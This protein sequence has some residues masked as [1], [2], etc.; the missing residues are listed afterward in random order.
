MNPRFFLYPVLLNGLL[1]SWPGLLLAQPAAPSPPVATEISTPPPTRWFQ[2]L[3]LREGLA[4]NF[5]TAI[6]QDRSGF[7]WIGTVKGLTRF[8]GRNCRNFTR[9]AGNPQSLSHRVVR[10]VLTARNGTLWVGTQ[11]GLD[12]YDPAVQ[13]FRRHSFERFGANGNIVSKLAET[14]DGILWCGTKDGLVRFDPV[15]GQAR[16]L[17][18]PADAA[19]RADANTI[20]S[21]LIN[22]PTI[23]VGTQAG[24]YA[25]NWRTN[26][27]RTFRHQES[28]PS[29]LPGDYVAALAKNPHTNELVVGTNNGFVALLDQATGAFRRLPLLAGNQAVASLLYTTT[30]ALWVGLGSGGLHQYNPVTNTFTAYLSEEL[31]PRSLGCNCVK[32]LFEDRNGLVWIVTDDVGIN[33]TNPTIEKF[34][35][36]FDEV[37]YRPASSLGLAALKLSVGKKNELWVAT[38]EGLLQID[39]KTRTFSQH[40]HNPKDPNSLGTDFLYTVLAD[41]RGV[42]WAGG[43][44]LTRFDLINNRFLRIPC[45]VSPDKTRGAQRDFVAGDQVFS[46]IESRDGRIFIGTSDKLT[47]YDPRTNTFSNRFT[48]EYIRKLPGKNY[49]ILYL[50]RHD[51]L[52]VGGFGPVYKISPDWQLLTQYTHDENNPNTLPDEGVTG[53][54]EDAAGYI[55]MATDNGLARLDERSGRFRTF[56]TQHGLPSN[57]ISSVLTTGDTLWVSTSRG[58]AFINTRLLRITAFDDDDGLP[59][60]EFGSDAITR[61]T[62][63]R[64]YIG[65]SRGVVSVQPRA[66]R[67]NRLVP[68]I[69]LTS[70]RV[71]GREFLRGPVEHPLPV[72]LRHVQNSFAFDMAALSFDNPAGN[73]FAYRLDGFEDRW[74]KVGNRPFASYTNVPPGDYILHIIGSNNDGVWNRQGY[75][76]SVRITPPFWQRWWFRFGVLALFV[77]SMVLIARWRENRFVREQHEKSDLRERIAA[78]E[79]KALRSQMNPHFLYNSLNSI[80]LFILQHDSDN[81]DH[82]LVKFSRLMRLILENSRQEW[83]TLASELDQLHLYLELEQLRFDNTFDFFIDTDPAIDQESVSIPPMIIQPYVENSILHGMAHKQGRGQISVRI[84]PAG[85]GLECRVEDDGVGRKKAAELKSKMASSHK[86]MG[87]QVTQERLNL[88]SQRDGKETRIMVI[89]TVDAQNRPTGT[90]VVIPLPT[91]LV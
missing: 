69:F 18:I 56:T 14:P 39:P 80:R 34:H 22:G 13:S 32:G 19:G 53:F 24:L 59:P 54:A 41:R 50:D 43:G 74:N 60:A 81:A 1:N 26:H 4:D 75:R 82:Y 62:T 31:N 9:Q 52:W 49:N 37:G 78:S 36:V 21:L 35:L 27:V 33:W 58:L 91:R 7:I 61:D 6:T 67:L 30:G 51:N 64:I 10:S 40:R 72:V 55:W 44:G 86:S 3:T 57:D 73:Q 76:L 45:L 42:V 87:L 66:M 17:R 5:T 84:T 8:D 68:P 85:E 83:V 12:R 90:T 38:H 28:T 89:D 47:I 16:H 25:Y 23:W 20:R 46:I 88:I 11:R 15:S 77:T 70:F 71:D 79:M 65:N 29:S 48:D 63:G 2:H